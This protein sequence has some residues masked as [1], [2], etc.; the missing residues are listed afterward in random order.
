[1]KLAF[2]V[3]RPNH[4]HCVSEKV[5]CVFFLGKIFLKDS[6]QENAICHVF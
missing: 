3:P 2:C 6:S 1:M 5:V 4:P